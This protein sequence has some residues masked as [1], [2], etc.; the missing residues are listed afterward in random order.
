MNDSMFCNISRVAD[1]E[2]NKNSIV[3]LDNAGAALP[4]AAQLAAVAH[5]L[6][7]GAPLGNPHSVNASATRSSDAIERAR[8]LVL[9]HCGVTARTHAVVF[10]ANATAAAKL[11]ADCTDWRSSAFV[12]SQVNHTSLLGLRATAHAHRA[13]VQML[14]ESPGNLWSLP[15]VAQCRDSQCSQ[16]VWLSPPRSEVAC[17]LLAVPLQC[18]FSGTV[19]DVADV[20]DSLRR[21]LPSLRVLVD[22]AAFASTHRLD[23]ARLDADFVCLSMYKLFGFPTGVGCLVAKIDAARELARHRSYFGG[24]T[25]ASLRIDRL[26][27]LELRGTDKAPAASLED[28]TA[29]FYDIA[30]LP[31]GFDALASLGGIDAIG[32]RTAALA[33]HLSDE[34]ARLRHE[35]GTPVVT[36][37]QAD[38]ARRRSSIVAF[39][40]RRADG[41]AVGFAEV[42][43]LARLV[44]LQLRTGCFCNVGACAFYLGWREPHLAAMERAQ[45]TCGDDNDVLFATADDGTPLEVQTGAVRVSFGSQSLPSDAER[46][47]DLVRRFFVDAVLSFAT[48]PAATT[49][50][51]ATIAELWIYPIKS[52]AGVRVRERALPLQR[53]GLKFDREF[54][55]VDDHDVFLS[56]KRV[57]RLALVQ[58]VIDFE[59]ETLTL[60]APD[61]PPLTLSLARASAAPPV[62]DDVMV[63][64]ARTTAQFN[65]T[66]DDWFTQF[67]G[68]RCRLARQPAARSDDHS[69]QNT[70]ALLLVNQT[71]VDDLNA[72]L[73][74]DRQIDHR[75]FRANLVV[76]GTPA[77]AEDTW[78]AVRVR[79]AIGGPFTLVVS[80]RCNRCQMINVASDTANMSDEPLR[81]LALYRRV[82]GQIAFGVHL[83]PTAASVDRL[84]QRAVAEGDVLKLLV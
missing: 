62:V 18:N 53:A 64:G 73:P 56:Q 26:D 46:V 7:H 11:V 24:G 9:A 6:Q 40:V 80:G 58:P 27:A 84:E 34:L 54:V 33:A 71:S 2:S 38:D 37:Y 50:A 75:P 66:G 36:L 31:A 82:R 74:A 51:V 44:G 1:D 63:C 60:T 77:F 69:F 14:R 20:I 59:R 17:S 22:A 4:T 5:Q 15:C 83:A 52:C 25:V 12:Y 61:M 49:S 70:S 57:P 3:Y 48:P 67:L 42:A 28:G 39:N 19:Y 10:V 76:S 16:C 43:T 41:S 47:L 68:R 8:E 78:R 81:T 65:G 32:V 79:G 45:R 30:A 35:N 55:V 13:P 23:L 72:R 21:R 29:N